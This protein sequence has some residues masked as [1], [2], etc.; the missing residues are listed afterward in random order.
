MQGLAVH[1]DKVKGA[2]CDEF[3]FLKVKIVGT[4]VL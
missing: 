3:S 4:E 2:Q 1:S